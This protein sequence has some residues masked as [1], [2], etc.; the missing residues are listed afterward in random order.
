V[1]SVDADART[2]VLT[3]GAEIDYD[4][5]VLALGASAVPAFAHALT[6]GAHPAALNGVLADLEEG[7]SRS[8]AFVVPRGCTWTLPLYELALMTAQSVWSMN[9]DQTEL[10]VVTPELEPLEIFGAGASAFVADLLAKARIT[11]HREVEARIP[12]TGRIRIG[13]GVE[14]VV[15]CVVALPVLEGPRL[16]G[17]PCDAGGFIPVDDVGRVDGLSGVYAIGDATDRPIKQGGLACQ[18]AD[19]TAAHIAAGAGA[20]VEVPALEQ[21]LRGRLLTGTHDHLLHGETAVDKPS[22]WAPAKVSGKY[23]SPYLVDNHIV[24]LPVRRAPGAAGIDVRI[25]LAREPQRTAARC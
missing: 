24:H 16:E 14:L 9:A 17:V 19:V 4:V 6:F 15:D 5:L 3:T 18:Q 23:L 25:P 13:G 21:V 2:V 1:A 8:I 12:F 20:D 7:W 22:L 11:V 10:H